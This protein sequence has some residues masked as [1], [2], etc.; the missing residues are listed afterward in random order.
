VFSSLPSLLELDISDN[1]IKVIEE[2]AFEGLVS[3]RKLRLSQNEFATFDFGA[4]FFENGSNNILM[5]VNLIFCA[6]Y[7]FYLKTFR[8]TGA[9]T[10]KCCFSNKVI[11]EM[12][13]RKLKDRSEL[14][15][16]IKRGVIKV[17]Q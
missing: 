17:E 16:L 3:L 12:N 2:K 8:A 7:S 10:A 1:K 11:M 6:I 13:T 4:H 5:P 9:S 15:M 14:Y